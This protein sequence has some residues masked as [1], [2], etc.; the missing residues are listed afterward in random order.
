METSHLQ[1][2]SLGGLAVEIW[3]LKSEERGFEACSRRF[4]IF[5]FIYFAKRV[6]FSSIFTSHEWNSRF[7]DLIYIKKNK[8]GYFLSRKMYVNSDYIARN[9]SSFLRS[10]RWLF[11]GVEMKFIQNTGCEHTLL[12]SE[13]DPSNTKSICYRDFD[14]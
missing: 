10:E 9:A 11:A 2:V 13:N 12:T 5:F 14:S 1:I 3:V 7:F 6:G 8:K 4:D